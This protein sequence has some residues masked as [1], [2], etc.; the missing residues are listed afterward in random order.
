MKR[1][2]NKVIIVTGGAGSI[3]S[4]AVKLLAQE[5]GKVLFCD[6]NI[7]AGKRL[8]AELLAVGLEAT[9]IE[10]DVRYPSVNKSLVEYAVEKYER[11]NSIVCCAGRQVVR[12][13]TEYE[14]DEWIDVFRLNCDSAFYLSKYAIPEMRKVNNGSIVFLGDGVMDMPIPKMGSNLVAKMALYY[15]CRQIGVE[16]CRYNI[17]G[18]IVSPTLVEGNYWADMPEAFDILKCCA[19]GK[20]TFV[21]EDLAPVILFMVSDESKMLSA[22]NLKAND[23]FDCGFAYDQWA[24]LMH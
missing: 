13:F 17:R 16:N 1:V 14:D 20:H 8:E 12:A 7:E 23:G 24:G 11:L 9:F 5:G 10:A 22:T 15:L 19:N 4:A 18:N 3:G 2:E 6:I 21:P